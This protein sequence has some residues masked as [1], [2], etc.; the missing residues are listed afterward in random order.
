MFEKFL[1]KHNLPRY[2]EDQILKAYYQDAISS[3]DD[4]STW[5]KDLR[6]DLKKEVEFSTLQKIKEQ[7]SQNG[8][9]IKILAYTKDNNPLEAVLM[10]TSK[11][12]SICV[13]CM[14]GCPVGCKFCATGQ[15]GFKKNLNS[16]E[17]IDQVMYF[18]R[19]LKKEDKEITNIV[20]MGMGEPMLNLD[21]VVS[22]IRVL[23][24]EKKLALSHRRITVSTAGY[25]SELKRFLNMNLGVKVAVS[26]HAPNQKLREKIMPIV[27]KH[28]KLDDLISLLIDYQKRTNKRITYEYLLLNGVNDKP[29]HAKE[30]A[31]LLKN[32]I[33]LVNLINFNESDGIPYTPSN[34]KVIDTFKNILEV[35]DINTTLR[36]SFGG[37]IDAACGQLAK[38]SG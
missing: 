7:I 34:N 24:D 9:T 22:A 17:I 16:Q 15:M 8:Q 38:K 36:H 29:E 5:S 2:R 27:S 14:S 23:T 26:L 3:W 28:N 1:T 4:L 20:F 25:L 11:R 31:K 12:N 6:E 19:I 10:K 18:K 30:L 33:A 13:S 21:N 37:D 35:R 32:Q